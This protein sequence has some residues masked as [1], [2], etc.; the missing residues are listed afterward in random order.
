MDNSSVK[1]PRLEGMPISGGDAFE[2]VRNETD[3]RR[4]GRL[5]T[6]L[7]ALYGQRSI[8]LARIRRKAMARLQREQGMSYAA[9]AA[10]FGLSK[11]RVGQ[12]S[13]SGPPL[14]RGLFG[15]GPIT[16]AI[17]LR[18]TEDRPLPVVAGEDAL[19]ADRATALLE[20]LQFEVKQ[21]RI[22]PGG[23]W[24]PSG[25]V[26]AICGPK[27]SPPVTGKAMAADPVLNFHEDRTGRWVI[28]DRATGQTFT[29]PID[30]GDP[31]RDAGYVG[32]LPFNGG[33][34]F[35]VAGIHALG[36]V[37]AI[38]YLSN[39]LAEM[40]DAVGEQHFSMVV[41]SSHDGD[42]VTASEALC[43]ARIHE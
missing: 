16:V 5:A 6:E 7:L 1:T 29:S 43:P 28:E 25:D 26:L 42:T 14:E 40:Y 31:S 9:V 35:I 21:F 32:R 10:E 37:G 30:D 38:D 11:G 4:Q 17:P 22:P 33:D 34:L 3:P 39:H 20:S 13:Q 23:A 18:A 8:E 12:I 27:S 19:A 15:T 24:T 2:A 36:S 41:E